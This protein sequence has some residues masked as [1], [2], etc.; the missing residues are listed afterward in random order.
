MSDRELTV[1]APKAERFPGAK[2]GDLDLRT[3]IEAMH[4]FS[5]ETELNRLLGFVM[6][7]IID[8]TAAQ[9]GFLLLERDGA[10]FVA[11]RGETGAADVEI[12]LPISIDECSLVPVGVIRSVA[13]TK[14]RAV[15]DDA[16]HQGEY[17]NDPHIKRE[18]TRSLFC[19]PLMSRG[20]L[21]G[22]LYL[23][24]NLMTRA[25]TPERVQLLEM[26]LSQ[27][28]I[29]L[30]NARVFK[31]LRESEAKYRRIVDTA[32]EGIW[33]LGPDA[34]ITFVN[35]RMV[36]MLGYKEEDVI[37]R[38]MTAFMFEEDISDALGKLE[39]RRRGLSENYEGRLR[40]KD[41]ETVWTLVS[42]T[43]LFDDEHHFRGS[44]AMFTDVTQRKQAEEALRESER[45]Q[46]LAFHV[47]Q[48]GAFEVDLQS[49]QG[50]WTPELAEIWGVPGDSTGDFGALFWENVHPEDFAQTKK[51]FAQMTPN[52][53]ESEMEFRIIRPDGVTRWIRWRGQVIQDSARGSSRAVGVNLDIT[54]RKRAEEER[55]AHLRF[56]ECLDQVNRAMQGTNDPEQMMSEALGAVLS[57]FDCDRAWLV[58]FSDLGTASWRAPMGR[59]RPEYPGAHDQGLEV[60]MDQEVLK[61][62]R[63]VRAAD[64]PVPFGPAT[65]HPLP[66]RSREQL[67]IRS[68][69]SMAL[70]PT[71]DKPYMFALHQCS[72]PRIWTAEEKRLF[73][74]VGRRLSDA[75]R[76]HSAYRE[77]RESENRYRRI[78]EGLTDYQYSVR[79]ENGRAAETTQSPA[80]GTVTG[81]TPEEFAADPFLWFR[82]VA[83]EDREL[84]QERV[85]QI[86]AGGDIPPL[87]HRILRKD[88][89]V[90]WVCD[91]TILLK[92]AFGK[93]LSY[94]GVIK[95]I[96]ERRQ[97]EE[98]L[99][100]LSLAVEQSPASVIMTNAGG[101]I[102]YV[103]PKF[104]KITGY[105]MDEV[106]GKN[107]RML[108]SGET[109]RDEYRRLW[110]AIKAGREW[111]GEFHNKKKSGE[112]FWESAS[113][114]PVRDEKGAITHFIAI[115]EDITERKRAEEELKQNEV[116]RHELE[117]ELIQA[118]KL[119]SLGTL[120]SGVAHDF[121]NIL[122]I[123][124]GQSSL[125]R[126]SIA[127]PATALRRI[128]AI[129]KASDRGASLVKQLLT[130]ARKGKTVFE[131]V[132]LNHI[133]NEVTNLL[134][135]T[136]PKTIT[137]LTNLNG[138]IPFITADAT[139]V[140]QVLVNLCINAR[141]AMPMGGS[142]T[143]I[144]TTVG[145]EAVA[146]Q[147]PRAHARQY[148]RVIVTDTGVGMDEGTKRKIFDP[149]FTTKGPGKGTGLGLAL[150]HSIVESHHGLI[151]TE[152]APGKGTTFSLY[153]PVEELSIDFFQPS[154]DIFVDIPRGTE[155]ILLIEDEEMLTE[156]MKETLV[157]KGYRVLTACNGE[158]GVEMFVRHQEQIAVVV[159]DLGLP[160]FGGD[161]VFKRIRAINPKAR[162]ILSSGLVDP[163]VM[164]EMLRIG[165]KLIIQKPY[166]PSEVLRA[167]RTALDA[168][169]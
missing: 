68:M 12:P 99:R 69:L 160:K 28:A 20:R 163:E 123:I 168:T 38:L 50:T 15:L 107:P 141:D 52:G 134:R 125:L 73:Q 86:L 53:K 1:L 138:E 54:E 100:K 158:E 97:S 161:E 145:Y 5:R 33:M 83:P 111:H 120:A 36:E 108:K 37:G 40:R 71:P 135:E 56:L 80:C 121:N 94:D 95:D 17:V 74:E 7:T 128:D 9:S 19:A 60:P 151:G 29:S 159:S 140:H 23:E 106:R 78:I 103:N 156:M 152:S 6:R 92:D 144:S 131:P 129:D 67:G 27:A 16:A 148:V 147:F 90:R 155:T 105:T 22:V 58:Y 102:E 49:G 166:S 139:Q 119:E 47:G 98:K 115:K 149:F 124:S 10:W 87:E 118:Q 84:V 164:G 113:I 112:L 42:S 162:V 18:K 57:I 169:D 39:N 116:R 153:F 75:L 14:E 133:I 59:T 109:E 26:L 122:A 41:G 117:R 76:S 13:R 72:S 3:L 167:I 77:L 2:A 154:P 35:A 104:T 30:E 85:Q 146:S 21:F 62:F 165:V 24:N 63:T 45:V 91:T 88:G 150:V 4:A 130:F 48:I 137:V 32:N 55:L 8:T 61:M 44:F 70:H 110:H 114:S 34:M 31:A 142:I 101:D 25:F 46:R 51:V 132:S 127:D 43:P 126:S 64:G 81:Y 11:A 93:L 65:E 82:M 136:L 157:A 143:I 66:K 96:T 89:A 79:I